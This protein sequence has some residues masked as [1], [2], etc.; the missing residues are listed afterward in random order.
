MTA[1]TQYAYDPSDLDKGF[2]VIEQNTRG[3]RFRHV[4]TEVDRGKLFTENGTWRT[5]VALALRAAAEDWEGAGSGGRLAATLRAA[6]TRAVG[7]KSPVMKHAAPDVEEVRRELATAIH[8]EADESS[9][10]V[11][12]G[13]LRALLAEFDRLTA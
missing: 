8:G 5:T 7:G 2:Y 13:D 1:P 11:P 12:V 6:A 4:W 3:D 10:R 9:I